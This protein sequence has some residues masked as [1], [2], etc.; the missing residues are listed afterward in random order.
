MRF[1]RA[2]NGYATR[3]ILSLANMS[4]KVV[5]SF[6]ND[7]VGVASC[8]FLQPNPTGEVV[9]KNPAQ[10][11]GDKFV[12]RPR[13]QLE[14]AASMPEDGRTGRVAVVLTLQKPAP[15]NWLARIRGYLRISPP[16]LIEERFVICDQEI[17]CPLVLP[18]GTVEPPRLLSAPDPKR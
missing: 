2:T 16:S 12:L 6:D 10:T 18:D 7:G 15:P 4:G 5:G 14:V 11:G 17:Q 3:A 8:R 13:S 1:D 9:W